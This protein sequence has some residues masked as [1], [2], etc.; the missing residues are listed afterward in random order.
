MVTVAMGSMFASMLLNPDISYTRG[1]TAYLLIAV[2]QY[3]VTTLSVRSEKFA[4]LVKA[5][6]TILFYEGRFL[7]KAMRKER[8]PKEEILSAIRQSGQ[9]APALIAA[10]LLESNGELIVMNKVNED[11]ELTLSSAGNWEAVSTEA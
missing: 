11:Q 5:D 3:I 10:V 2:L 8:V 4:D 6:P 7:E 9:G 1:I